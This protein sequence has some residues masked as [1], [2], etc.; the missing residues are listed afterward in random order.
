MQWSGDGASLAASGCARHPDGPSSAC[1]HSG[2]GGLDGC[3]ISHPDFMFQL[4]QQIFKPL[5]VSAG[6][7][8]D[9]ARRTQLAVKMLGFTVAVLRR[10]P[11][12]RG[13][14][15]AIV[16][17]T[18]GRSFAAGRWPPGAKN[19]ACDWSSFSLASRCR[20]PSWRASTADCAMNV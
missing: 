9:Q 16:V 10:I 20:M 4:I 17:W 3:C 5:R 1:A 19:G 2:P 6:L 12:E 15:E 14:P 13:L 8:T 7:K 18:M 11:C